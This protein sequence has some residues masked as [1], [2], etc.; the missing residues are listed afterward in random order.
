MDDNP[1]SEAD[2]IRPLVAV[3]MGS[4]SDWATMEHT[5]VMLTRFNVPHVCRIVSAHR[6]PQ[7]MAEFANNAERDGI[8]VIIAAAGGAAHLPGMTAAHTA[9]P[10]LGVP[11]E[12]A[13]LRGVDSL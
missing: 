4:K 6:T 11:I 7:L 5:K 9:L 8:E 10:V 2:G 1:I 13:V 12:S 3:I